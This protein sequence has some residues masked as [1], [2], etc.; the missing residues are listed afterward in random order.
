VDAWYFCEFQR[1]LREILLCLRTFYIREMKKKPTR[2]VL[3]LTK[4]F[5]PILFFLLSSFKGDNSEM[6][7]R[8]YTTALRN[9]E[10]LQRYLVV[11]VADANKNSTREF[12]VLGCFFRH[13][14]HQEWKIDYDRLSEDLVVAKAAMNASRLFDFK[15]AEAVT[16]L[17]LDLYSEEDLA[18]LQKQ[19][20]FK[21]LSK[22][23]AGAGKWQKS[24]GED[25]KLM[26]MYAHALFNQGIATGENINAEG[27]VLVFTP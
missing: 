23:I 5:L 20:D 24:F 10:N 18:Q 2:K 3:L 16:Y 25:D 22:E 21:K 1:D 8:N 13:A 26:R 19:V 6:V 11:R 15:N 12:C 4:S 7:F 9:K 27:G 17:G 14:L